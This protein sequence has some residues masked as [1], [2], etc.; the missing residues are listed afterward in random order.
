MKRE[1]LTSA[2]IIGKERLI[3]TLPFN[4]ACYVKDESKKTG[5]SVSKI[6]E[7]ILRAHYESDHA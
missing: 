4:V 7:S 2:D 1:I 6:V 5:D 3:V